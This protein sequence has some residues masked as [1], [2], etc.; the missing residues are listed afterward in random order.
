MIYLR[1]LVLLLVIAGCGDNSN[2]PP[3]PARWPVP[4]TCERT[5]EVN[6]AGDS[7]TWDPEGY[8]PI[9]KA[10]FL[11]HEVASASFPGWTTRNF[12]SYVDTESRVV[13]ILLGTNDAQSLKMPVLEFENR[14]GGIIDR[15]IVTGGVCKVVLMTPPNNLFATP[16]IKELLEGYRE[17]IKRFCSGSRDAVVC[18]PELGSLLV[19]GDF[20]DLIHPGPSGAVKIAAGLIPHLEESEE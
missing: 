6:L 14:L 1:F 2:P 16:E 11:P 4:E 12:R 20:K 7:I 19:G 17:V 5:R 9:V 8:G 18:G 13:S 3:D 10:E 15:Q